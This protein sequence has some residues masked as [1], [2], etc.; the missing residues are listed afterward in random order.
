MKEDFASNVASEKLADLADYSGSPWV[1]TNS[2][3]AEAEAH[4]PSLWAKLVWPFIA[5]CAFTNVVDLAAGQGRNTQFLCEM[6]EH[7]TVIDIQ[8]GNI[9]I[10]KERFADRT[11]VSFLVNNGFDFN[12]VPDGQISLIYCFDAMVHFDSDVVRSYLHDACRI[13]KPGGRA[14]LHHSNYTGGH[15]WRTNPSS[16]NFMSKELFAH[17]AVKE[18]LRVIR[19]KVI[20][21]GMNVNLDCLTLIERS[22]EL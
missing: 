22:V 10:C 1:P 5:D 20:N 14:F 13:L 2:Y 18:K 21:W 6:A 4:M 3:F 15:D 8:P 17:Y 12:P 19:Q 9:A 11:G 16:R 7:V